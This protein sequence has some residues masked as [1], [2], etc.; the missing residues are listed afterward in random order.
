MI[1]TKKSLLLSMPAFAIVLALIFKFYG[2]FWGIF[3]V[4]VSVAG[5]AGA[6][7]EM[8]REVKTR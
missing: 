8:K 4:V 6:L 1:I 7:Q 3:Y 5:V 2:S